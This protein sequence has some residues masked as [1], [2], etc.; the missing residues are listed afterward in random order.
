MEKRLKLGP[1]GIPWIKTV[2]STLS[3]GTELPNITRQ[4]LVKIWLSKIAEK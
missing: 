2:Q 4:Q 1:S 3:S